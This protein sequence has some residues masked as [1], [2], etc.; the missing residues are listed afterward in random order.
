MVL[1]I[2]LQIQSFQHVLSICVNLS[3][4]DYELSFLKNV[5]LK[6]TLLSTDSESSSDDAV[7]VLHVKDGTVSVESCELSGCHAKLV[8][9][10]FSFLAI[11]V[12]VQ[13][14]LSMKFYCETLIYRNRT[15]P[16]N[17]HVYLI[18]KDKKLK[19]V[20]SNIS[21]MHH[22]TMYFG[23]YLLTIVEHNQPFID[24]FFSE[25]DNN[26]TLLKG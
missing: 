22:M 5:L 23:I 11:V 8:N 16:L 14:Y 3:S 10:T 19:K 12:E 4:Q 21:F 2:S 9:P 6:P 18:L 24:F 26:Q 13:Q 1:H 17:L 15:T 7:K 20:K 25:S